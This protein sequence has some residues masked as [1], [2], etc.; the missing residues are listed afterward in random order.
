MTGPLVRWTVAGPEICRVV[1]EFDDAMKTSKGSD[2][3]NLCHHD[4]Y[5]AVQ[6]K[7]QQNVQKGIAV[8]EVW[9]SP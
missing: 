4:Q 5:A 1:G 9:G 2:T 6:T 3:Q 7:F 8:F